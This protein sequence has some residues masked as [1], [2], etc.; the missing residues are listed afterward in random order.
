MF[1]LMVERKLM[2]GRRKDFVLTTLILLK[3]S[4]FVAGIFSF[5]WN[6]FVS[7][8]LFITGGAFLVLFYIIFLIFL[9]RDK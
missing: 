3:V 1:E 5:I 6:S 8:I 9:W 7:E 4:C 2:F